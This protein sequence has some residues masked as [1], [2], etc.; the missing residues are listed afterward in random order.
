M[1]TQ[2]HPNRT[3]PVLLILM[4]FNTVKCRLLAWKNWENG[5][6]PV[7]MARYSA[8]IRNP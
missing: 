3:L 7:K 6:N 4:L 8:E 2:K 1:F 5:G